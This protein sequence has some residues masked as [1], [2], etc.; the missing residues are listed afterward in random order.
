MKSKLTRPPQFPDMP[1]PRPVA[2]FFDPAQ[3]GW[4]LSRYGD[5]LAALR[6][7]AVRQAGLQKAPAH[8]RKD[9]SNALSQSKISEWQEQIEPVAY[10]VIAELP[11]GRPIELVSEVLRPWSL[12]VMAIVLGLDAAAGRKLA[13]FQPRLPGSNADSLAPQPSRLSPQSVWRSVQR[14]I[15]NAR[16]ERLLRSVSVPGAHSLFLGLS[17]TLPDFLANAWF[18]LLQHPSDLVRLRVEPYL[19]PRAVD[20][21]LR[22]SG[23]VHTL[24]READR[25]LELAGVTIARG[26]RVILKVALAN[27]D[28]EHFPDPNSLDIA[29][30]NAGH[31]A[32]GAGPHSCVGALL[33]RMAAI[34]ATRA[35]TKT[36]AGAELVDPVVWRRGSTLDS[37]SSLRVRYDPPEISANRKITPSTALHERTTSGF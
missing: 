31:L 17:Q 22:Y 23:L 10:R 7:P 11:P 21:L 37:P 29:R 13:A 25:T 14:K 35:F 24:T 12:A 18:A 27:R 6:E 36:M 8:V 32:L 30:Q 19:M 4:V 16:L 3:N 20:E 33:V 15:A 5:V 28:P 26:D 1:P 2:P 34:S 9:V